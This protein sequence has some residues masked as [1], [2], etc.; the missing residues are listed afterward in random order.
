[1]RPT[2]RLGFVLSALGFVA[3]GLAGDPAGEDPIFADDFESGECASWSA[4]SQPLGGPD[5]DEDG[6]GDASLPVVYCQL[7]PDIVPDASD[8]DDDDDLVHPNAAELCNT[9]DD[10]CDLLTADGAD[11]PSLGDSCDGLGDSDQCEEGA[12]ACDAGQLYCDDPT[13][14]TVEL[15]AGDGADED[16]DGSI[17]EGF[18]LD[19]NPACNGINLGSLP[20]DEPADPILLGAA[21]EERYF[22]L[23]TDEIGCFNDTIGIHAVLHSPPGVDYDLYLQCFGCGGTNPTKAA[24]THNL[25]GHD[26]QLYFG[27][28]DDCDQDETHFVLVEV[29]YFASTLCAPWTLTI[30]GDM[31]DDRDRTCGANDRPNA[32]RASAPPLLD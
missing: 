22:L 2:S 20:G 31:T 12:R 17:D 25:T 24:T 16:C 6:Y 21:S 5:F 10:D 26:D 9:V 23:V 14:S 30:T 13:S 11:E 32:L 3:S 7:P 15:C 19:D 29:R 8:C 4:T 18:V 1:M 27:A 28:W